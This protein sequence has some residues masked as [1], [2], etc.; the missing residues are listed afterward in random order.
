MAE[1]YFDKMVKFIR[2]DL[3]LT[4]LPI[5]NVER[6]YS[7]DEL[8][9]VLY[10]VLP[11]LNAHGKDEISSRPPFDSI[12]I[13]FDKNGIIMEKLE[14]ETVTNEGGLGNGGKIEVEF[15]HENFLPY[16]ARNRRDKDVQNEISNAE[17]TM[18]RMGGYRIDLATSN[19]FRYRTRNSKEDDLSGLGRIILYRKADPQKQTVIY[20]AI[21]FAFKRKIR[22]SIKKGKLV[23]YGRNICD[24]VPVKLLFNKDHY[25]C[26]KD[27]HKG[28]YEFLLVEFNG[29]SRVTLDVQGHNGYKMY[30]TFDDRKVLPYPNVNPNVNMFYMLEC[31]ENDTLGMTKREYKRPSKKQFCP[32]CHKEINT[33]YKK[34]GS[35][36]QM[37]ASGNKGAA[38]DIEEREGGPAKGVVCCSEDMTQWRMSTSAFDRVLPKDYLNRQNFKLAILGSGRSGKTTFISR[39]FNVTPDGSGGIMMGT[40]AVENALHQRTNKRGFCTISNYEIKRILRLSG[41]KRMSNDAWFTQDGAPHDFYE[42]YVCDPAQGIFPRAT[43]SASNVTTPERDPF[44]Y[45]FILDVNN[46]HYISMYDIAGEDVERNTDRTI[47]L[48]DNAPIGVFYIINGDIDPAG[49]ERA[50]RTIK[51]ILDSLADK[52]V[53][54]SSCPFA[55]IASK[56]DRLERFFDENCFCL[57]SDTQDMMENSYE[58]SRLEQCIDFA[59]EEVKAFL[60]RLDPFRD[61][62]D[63]NI[64]YFSASSFSAPD[65]IFHKDDADGTGEK[66]YLKYLSS[67]KRIELPVIWM[68]KQFGCIT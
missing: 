16:Y 11:Q 42:K 46:R 34:G 9:Y 67:P 18:M 19:G 66:N 60:G 20:F 58:G 52:K 27:D 1:Y 24:K 49:A 64:K 14:A 4:E 56:F 55:V 45:P 31:I 22:Y 51:R 50:K 29:K 5:F 6:D 10:F 36:C 62:T 2:N 25:P 61:I 8:K 57:R 59:S 40:E 48:F 28:N 68:L 15:R 23:F 30:V 65:S 47:K 13:R 63:L 54:I 33:K 38:L 21:N 37:L 44:K 17:P 35:D 53:D 3:E 32:F 26:L 41:T 39:M 12:E 7:D 43:D